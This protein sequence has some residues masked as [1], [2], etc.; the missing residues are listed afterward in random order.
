VPLL[1]V[2]VDLISEENRHLAL[3]DREP[4]E[5]VF[6]ATGRRGSSKARYSVIEFLGSF[7]RSLSTRVTCFNATFAV[8][9]GLPV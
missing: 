3:I 8:C 7:G 4:D 6:E 2:A 9:S 1:D 5:A